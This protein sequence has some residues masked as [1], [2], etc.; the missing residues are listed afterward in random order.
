MAAMLEAHYVFQSRAT[1]WPNTEACLHVDACAAIRLC[2]LGQLR[3]VAR[4]RTQ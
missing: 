2:V 1:S 4:G 3:S